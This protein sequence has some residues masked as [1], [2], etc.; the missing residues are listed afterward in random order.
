MESSKDGSVSDSPTSNSLFSPD[1]IELYKK[2]YEE[3]YDLNDPGYIAWLK[4]NHPTEF[5]S[6]TAKSSSS[7][8]SSVLSTES[9][10][11]ADQKS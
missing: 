11:S 1:Q 2:R 4:I 5:C 6:N 10:V 3:G 8:V 9:K 7:L